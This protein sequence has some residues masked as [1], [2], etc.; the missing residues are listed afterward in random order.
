LYGIL[1]QLIP[2]VPLSLEWPAPSGSNY[3][4]EEWAKFALDGCKAYLN[5]YQAAR[6]A[7]K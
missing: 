7:K 5:D 6:G 1:D 3:T 4:P 2:E